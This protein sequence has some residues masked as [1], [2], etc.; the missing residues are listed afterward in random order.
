MSFSHLRQAYFTPLRCS[1]SESASTS[2]ASGV[3]HLPTHNEY[4]GIL[5]TWL[6]TT[7]S[8]Y[9]AMYTR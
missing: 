8:S 1:K 4:A 5:Y 6:S 7:P 2:N 9:S 3:R